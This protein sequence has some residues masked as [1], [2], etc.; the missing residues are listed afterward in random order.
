[1]SKRDAAEGLSV[2]LWTCKVMMDR[3]G[4]TNAIVTDYQIHHKLKGRFAHHRIHLVVQ[5]LVLMSFL[6]LP[7]IAACK[8][9]GLPTRFTKFT[10]QTSFIDQPTN[11]LPEKTI[12][13]ATHFFGST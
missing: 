2:Y 13:R 8:V 11:N 7:H 9:V 6:L 5:K 10:S 1:M 3:D 4:S 12:Q